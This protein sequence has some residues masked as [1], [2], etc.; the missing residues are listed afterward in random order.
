MCFTRGH[1][2]KV[3]EIDPKYVYQ[4][5][6]VTLLRY[7]CTV[8]GIKGSCIARGVLQYLSV[9]DVFNGDMFL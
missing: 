1:R 5:T 2:F 9:D 6:T 4:N 8:C 7:Q 3:V